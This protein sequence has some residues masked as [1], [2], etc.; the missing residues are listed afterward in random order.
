LAQPDK[1]IHFVSKARQNY[2]DCVALLQTGNA[3]QEKLNPNHLYM[4]CE[5][6]SPN[7]CRQ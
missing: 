2:P 5:A 3:T 6:S 1:T 7:A 4:D